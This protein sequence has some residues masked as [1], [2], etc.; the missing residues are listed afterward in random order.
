[1]KPLSLY[2][3][4]T[5]VELFQV[6]IERNLEVSPGVDMDELVSLL[7]EDD[8]EFIHQYDKHSF[9]DLKVIAK[10]F[11]LKGF[12]KTKAELI[13]F[14]VQSPPTPHW[15]RLD[16]LR[17]WKRAR[18]NKSLWDKRFRPQ[19]KWI[20]EGCVKKRIQYSTDD[21]L[22][23]KQCEG[24]V[25]GKKCKKW[26]EVSVEVMISKEKYIC[27]DCMKNKTKK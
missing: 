11:G 15:T 1:M 25:H 23:Q 8:Y 5:R 16:E 3:A 26:D 17:L 24:K 7:Q 6:A 18:R 13:K 10:S 9:K 2:W 12:V 22:S 14:L 21:Y 4:G 19:P 27:N 20:K